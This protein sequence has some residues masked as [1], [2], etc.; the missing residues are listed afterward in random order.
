MAD[1]IFKYDSIS[2]E[3]EGKVAVSNVSFSLDK[4]RILA[5]VGESGSG[6]TTIIKSVMG[7]L[8]SDATIKNGHIVFENENLLEKN[9]KQL[10]AIRGKKIGMIFQ[11]SLGAFCPIRTIGQQIIE[12]V[13]AHYKKD[14]NEIKQEA[15]ALFDKLNLNNPEKLWKSYPFELSGGMNQRVGIAIAML[16]NPTLL[17]ADEPTS[18]IDEKAKKMVLAELKRIRDSYG[19][20][21]IIVTH[22]MTVVSEI[23]DEVIVLKDG[24]VVEQGIKNQVLE[25]PKAEYTRQLIEAVPTSRSEEWKLSLV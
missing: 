18:A 19:T 10:R 4:G 22:D 16:L 13:K 23:A 11:D 24:K 9:E 12:A 1:T 3:Y 7:I 14:K 20:S 15:L 8:N 2:I 6:K 21:I 17:L 5:L 25:N